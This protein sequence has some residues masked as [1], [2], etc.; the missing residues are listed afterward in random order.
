MNTE[1]L[2]KDQAE[3]INYHRSTGWTI[4]RSKV[5]TVTFATRPSPRNPDHVWVKA[6][7]GTARVPAWNYT[8]P[9]A[10]RAEAAA[11]HLVEST[12]RSELARAETTAKR[13]AARAALKASNFW[14]VGD[15]V[16]TSWGYD[17]T[18]VDYFQ[19][20]EVK[21][22]SV[23][24]RSIKVNSSDHGQ[25]GGGRVAPRRYEFF[26]PEIYCPIDEAGGFNAGPCRNA[27]KPSYRHR[28]Y[29]WDGKSVYTSSD[30]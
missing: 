12:K 17:Q 15:V 2:A 26:G 20:T 10:A 1:A 3:I 9:T 25:P 21:P 4:H 14:S 8:F 6:W 23:I 22:K 24:V 27:D 29:K 7:T 13:K 19:I 11:T 16:Y 18:N 28:C 30:R 5:A